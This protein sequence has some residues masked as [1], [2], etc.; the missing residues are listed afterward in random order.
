MKA[1]S[2]NDIKH[3]LIGYF[4]H[5]PEIEVAYI[6][7]SLAQC[8]TT[9]LSDI[10]IA[11]M[12]DMQQIDMDIYPYGYK[13][14]IIADLMKLFKT[15]NI[16]LVIL[17]EASPLLR[18]RVL[19]YGILIFSNNESKRIRFHTSTI[20]KYNDYKYL[21]RPHFDQGARID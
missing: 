9:P 12:I 21:M 13:A 2:V 10:D 14:A 6:F 1:P 8:R 5:H 18:H 16:D 17:N 20:D 15:N 3:T 19:Y 11:I 7:G 4:Q